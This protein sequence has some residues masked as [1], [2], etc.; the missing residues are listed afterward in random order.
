[1]IQ[2]FIKNHKP[3]PCK[4][5]NLYK[6][7]YTAITK[8]YQ[9]LGGVFRNGEARADLGEGRI[10]EW[11]T[12]WGRTVEAELGAPMATAVLCARGARARERERRRWW[13]QMA[14]GTEAIATGRSWWP[15]RA[16]PSHRMRA[17]RRP[18]SAGSQQRHGAAVRTRGRG[19][20]TSAGKGASAGG[21]VRL[22]PVGQKRGRSLLAPPFPFSIF[23]E[24]L[25]S[26]LFLNSFG[27]FQILF[28][29]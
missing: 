25:F 14:A 11:L 4:H 15:S 26:I 29:P 6:L 5:L 16:R 1:M 27:L 7:I 18:S 23:F 12:R 3:L 10:E 9:A 20:S 28:Q 19:A 2:L 13:A 21:L 17:T 8:R 22:R 24:F